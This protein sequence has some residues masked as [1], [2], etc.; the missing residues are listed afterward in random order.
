MKFFTA[1]RSQQNLLGY[2]IEDF[3]ITKGVSASMAQFAYLSLWTV[4]MVVLFRFLTVEYIMSNLVMVY[5]IS[6]LVYVAFMV[7]CLPL[8]A[9]EPIPIVIVNGMM[10]TVFQYFLVT[11]V[12][13][14]FMQYVISLA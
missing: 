11:Y 9:R 7:I 8:L 6:V 4:A 10:M 3:A 14:A 13:H 2:R 1:N 12:G 5:M